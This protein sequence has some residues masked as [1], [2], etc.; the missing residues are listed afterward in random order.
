MSNSNSSSGGGIG[1]CGIVFVVFLILKLAEVGVV[2][3]WSWWWVTA[4]LWGP[5]AL[6]LA[7]LLF[8]GMVAGGLAFV[9]F[10]LKRMGSKKSTPK[11]S[12]R[13]LRRTLRKS[14]R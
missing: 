10:V 11:L 7:V 13:S 3:N 4:P 9:G 12:S 6:V 14:Q 5:L 1:L 8:I 2:A